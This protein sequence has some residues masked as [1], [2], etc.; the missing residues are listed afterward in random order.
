VEQFLMGYRTYAQVAARRRAD[1]V[2]TAHQ[3]YEAQMTEIL[4]AEAECGQSLA[5]LSKL[6]V[7]IEHLSADQHELDAKIAALQQSPQMKDACALERLHRES[8]ERKKDSEGALFELKDAVQTQKAR[9]EEHVRCMT[10][11]EQHEARLTN[12]TSA[13]ANAAQAAGLDA[14]HREFIAAL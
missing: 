5:E 13:A 7:E 14:G 2:W 1:R 4:A 9:A 11:F 12:A 8:R 3:Q 10:A 6:K